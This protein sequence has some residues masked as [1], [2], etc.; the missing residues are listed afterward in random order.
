MKR[1]GCCFVLLIAACCLI[2]PESGAAQGPRKGHIV[3]PQSSEELPADVGVNAHTHI[4]AMMPEKSAINP[5]GGSGAIAVVDAFDDPNAA[6]DLTAFA[7]QFGLPPAQFQVV[8]AGGTRPKVDLTDGWELE[9]SLDIEWSHAMAP[10]AK[11]FLVEANSNSF[12]DL[13]TAIILAA[14]IVASNGGGEVSMSFGCGEFTQETLFDAIFTQPGV[15]YIASTGDAPGTEWPS[16][17]PNVIAAGGT[18]ISRDSDSGRFLLENSWQDAGGGPSLVEQRPKFQDH[19]SNIVNGAR[20]TPDLAFDANPSTGVWVVD[21]N[22]FQGQTA[23]WYVVGGTSVSAPSLAGIINTAG[24]FASSSQA[25]LKEIYDHLGNPL[26]FR[27]VQYGTCGI[28]AG[29]LSL[30]GWDFCTGVGSP[31]S[32]R[33]K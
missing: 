3:V 26:A 13:F 12:N 22:P 16:T 14:E 2:F 8:F 1:M 6:A 4:L 25:E 23:F 33:D 9:E 10:K 19:I 31:S 17:S 11:I 28:N 20:G 7:K 29:D 15:A 21:T 24:S 27:D 30:P 18:T 32:Y 5:Q